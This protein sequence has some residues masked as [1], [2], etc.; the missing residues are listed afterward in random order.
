MH[1]SEKHCC[2]VSCCAALCCA[3]LC[4]AEVCN[5]LQGDQERAAGLAVSPLM[6]RSMKGGMTRSQVSSPPTPYPP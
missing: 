3:V 4:C 1:I 2:A 6:D 5:G